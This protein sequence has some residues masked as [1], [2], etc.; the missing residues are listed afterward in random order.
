MDYDITKPKISVMMPVWNGERYIADAIASILSQTYTDF[1]LLVLNDG[2]TDKTVEIVQSFNDPR[3]RIIN[4]EKNQGTVLTRNNGLT[5]CRGEYVAML[6]ADDLAHPTRFQKQVDFLDSHPDFGIVGSW[7]DLIDANS[8]P[9]GA[10]WKIDFEPEETP[11]LL[12]LHTCFSFS[13][14]MLR[15]KAI[16]SDGF[17]LGY[18]PAEDYEIWIRITDDGWKG[19]NLPE[20]LTTYR[21]HPASLSKQKADLQAEVVSTIL[22][23]QLKKLNIIPTDEEL[24][25]HRAHDTYRGNDIAT[26]LASREKWLLRLMKE[27]GESGKYAKKT[28]NRVMT[29]AWL[30]TCKGN[31]ALGF[32]TWNIFWRSPLSKNIR[33]KDIENLSKFLIKCVIKKDDR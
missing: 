6:D 18:I 26:F 8:K 27:N 24:K 5:H 10:S 23:S 17:R 29:E 21:I 22:R 32:S 1:E 3:I 33:I 19:Y 2:S 9:L 12:L 15:K 25:I 7:V 28:F 14:V 11:I 30:K 20:L 4:N 16:P 31:T 13:A